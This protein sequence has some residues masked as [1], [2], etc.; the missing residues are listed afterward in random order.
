MNQRGIILS[1]LIYALLTFFLLLLGSILI[2]LTHRLAIIEELKR[3]AGNIFYKVV[4]SEI[5]QDK[6]DCTVIA[7]TGNG[8][9]VVPAGVNS[10]EVLV[11][12]GGGSGGGS[13]TD[14]TASG[15][16]G[17]GG[18]VHVTNFVVTPGQSIPITVGPGGASVSTNVNG[19]DGGNSTFGSLVATGGGG[20]AAGNPNETVIGA[21][22]GRPG[23]SGGGAGGRTEAAGGV[24]TFGQGNNGGTSSPNA[25]GLATNAG[26]GGGGAGQ[27]GQR[28]HANEGGNGGDGRYFGNV[29]GIEYGANGWFA[30]GGGGG[31]ET[32]DVRGAGGLGGGGLGAGATVNATSG[33]ANTGSGGGGGQHNTVIRAS[34]AGGSGIVL[35][36]YCGFCCQYKQQVL[37][38]G[39]VWTV[40][41]GVSSVEVLVIG[42]GGSGGG[43]ATDGTASGGGGAGGVVYES[44]YVVTPGQAI[45]VAV[46][47]GGASVN[48]NVNGND[49]GSS[50][51]GSLIAIGGGG[52]AAGNPNEG[53]IGA[54]PGRPGGSGGGA[55]GRTAAPGGNGLTG[56]GHNGGTTSPNGGGVGTNAGGGGGGAGQVGQNGQVNI[57]G[58]G[59]NGRYYG[60]IFGVSVGSNG[61]FGGGG[62]GGVETGTNRGTGGQGG[63]GTGA[64]ATI[65][66]T[67]GVANTGGGGG[68]GQHNTAIR[69]SG[70]GG[71]GVVIIR[72]RIS[73]GELPEYQKIGVYGSAIESL[74]SNIY[75]TWTIP[76]AVVNNGTD[77]FFTGNYSFPRTLF[78]ANLPFRILNVINIPAQ[79]VQ[80]I[81][82]G[83]NTYTFRDVSRKN[84]WTAVKL[85][86]GS[87]TINIVIG[88]F[89]LVFINDVEYTLAEAVN[90]G[91]IEP[92]VICSSSVSNSELY[93]FSSVSNVISGGNTSNGNYAELSIQYKTKN[94]PVKAIKFSSS[95]NYNQ[96]S[97]GLIIREFNPTYDISL[98][99]F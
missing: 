66:A 2:V 37:T 74:Y 15:G 73:A 33:V 61:W 98:V 4:D 39:T 78:S 40:P 50:I 11:V 70:A 80:Y 83:T 62:G 55:G 5:P 92:L 13:A 18:L 59:G 85:R 41:V 38:T 6:F 97:D 27:I 24:G 84:N 1:G 25:G 35:I 23:G 94:I 82:S 19:N 69:P 30:G 87:S 47:T 75:G 79:S 95:V 89:R 48:T 29:F 32:G 3:E 36:K 8:S 64:G 43:S 81:Y 16:G 20:G 88:S 31:V 52:G 12:A 68:G 72:Y 58:T 46:G 44:N 93:I 56:Q 86:G 54:L 14:G 45:N 60:E 57:G 77:N 90:F 53:V 49:G 65:D 17:A 10:V 96:T 9:W 28:G 34:G 7:Y 21:L 26:G 51:F 67:S 71:S 99:S 22:P 91:Y 63:G 42:G 76:N